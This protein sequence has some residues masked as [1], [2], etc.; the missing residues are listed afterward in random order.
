MLTYAIS[1]QV[2]WFAKRGINWHIAVSLIKKGTGFCSITHVHIFDT[3]ISQDASITSQILVD[4]AADIMRMNPDIKNI[5][6]FS[7][8][9]GCY[10]SSATISLI[11]TAL[12]DNLSSYNFSEAQDGKGNILLISYKFV[13][14]L[15]EIKIYKN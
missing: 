4:V 13:L 5:H 7:D 15:V 9:A 14:N 1:G 8:N 6:Y 10:K 12:G 11:H 3:P 2:D